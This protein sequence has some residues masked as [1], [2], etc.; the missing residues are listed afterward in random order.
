[1]IVTATLGRRTHAAPTHY[2]YIGYYPR[3]CDSSCSC[4]Q[5]GLV[6]KDRRTRARCLNVD[7]RHLRAGIGK[8]RLF[9]LPWC[10]SPQFRSLSCLSQKARK[11]A[12]LPFVHLCAGLLHATSAGLSPQIT[13]F[14]V[15][16]PDKRRCARSHARLPS[17]IPQPL[18][19]VTKRASAPHFHSSSVQV[20]SMLHRQ[21]FH[22]EPRL[23]LFMGP[24]T[25]EGA[26]AR[27]PCSRPP[28]VLVL[29]LRAST[30]GC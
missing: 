19:P 3:R 24:T 12:S 5:C 6:D 21:V 23:L 16:G 27:R 1:M 20:Y 26:P 13:P 25:N 9:N 15:H 28:C 17:S 29:L 8:L 10:F 7:R 30:L 2:L 4:R 22:H 14:I 11:R 18:L